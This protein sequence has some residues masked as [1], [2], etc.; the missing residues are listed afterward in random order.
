M[1]WSYTVKHITLKTFLL[2]VSQ[3]LTTKRMIPTFLRGK[4][5]KLFFI[6]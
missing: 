6:K 3:K 2:E 1:E 4:Y 5:L